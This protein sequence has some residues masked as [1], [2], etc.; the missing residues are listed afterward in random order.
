MHISRTN[1][2]PNPHSRICHQDMRKPVVGGRTSLGEETEFVG[3][4]DCIDEV[5][6]TDT[7]TVVA[8]AEERGPDISC[9]R[10]TP[11][12]AMTWEPPP[13]IASTQPPSKRIWVGFAHAKQPAGPA[14]E[15]LEQL[16]SQS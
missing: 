13:Q 4:V 15:Q 12:L 9:E 8:L 14:P 11:S 1:N 2:P 10:H 7:V 3:E 5:E 6:W 16:A